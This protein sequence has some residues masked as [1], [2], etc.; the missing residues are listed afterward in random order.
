VTTLGR[1]AGSATRATSSQLT[2]SAQAQLQAQAASGPQ[3]AQ[4]AVLAT[5]GVLA[6]ATTVPLATA[7]L[8]T[9][10]LAAG[11]RRPA[12]QSALSA[13]M[14]FP[15][16]V[17][18]MIGPATRNTLNL[19]VLRRAQFTLMAAGRI[20]DDITQARSA[21]RPGGIVQALLDGIERERRFYGQHL[22][23]GW[24]RMDAAARVDAA[25]SAHGLLLGWNAV[26]DQNTSAEC[27]AAD[28]R[29]FRADYMPV[30]GYPGAVH[31]HCRCYPGPA[32]RGAPMMAG[33]RMAA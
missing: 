18:G 9:A 10:Y 4:Q 31:P 20:N 25:A 8:A 23:A 24:N 19:N 30:I 29:N 26:H 3:A 22:T 13:V 12:L 16:D 2:S 1:L 33:W 11:I 32:R 21:G 14:S 5:A 6:V 28:G 15:P 7:A 27:R 17:Q